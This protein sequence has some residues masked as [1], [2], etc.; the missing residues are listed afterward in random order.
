MQAAAQGQ[1]IK[2]C[3]IYQIPVRS[4]IDRRLQRWSNNITRGLWGKCGRRTGAFRVISRALREAAEVV[5][6]VKLLFSLPAGR[7]T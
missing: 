2:P 5:D 6:D 3:A 7:P 4:P 1:E